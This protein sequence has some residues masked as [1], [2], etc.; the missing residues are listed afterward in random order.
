MGPHDDHIVA[1]AAGTW[2][3]LV[4]TYVALSEFARRKFIDGGIPAS[5]MVVKPNFVAADPGQGSHHW[6]SRLCA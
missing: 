6:R 3:D 1:S 5:R 4:H 2:Q